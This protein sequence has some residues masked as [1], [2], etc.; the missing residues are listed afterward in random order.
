MARLLSSSFIKNVLL[1]LLQKFKTVQKDPKNAGCNGDSGN[2]YI[3]SGI[4]EVDYDVEVPFRNKKTNTT[5]NYTYTKKDVKFGY[6][7]AIG[8]DALYPDTDKNLFIEFPEEEVTLPD[9]KTAMV[10]P[11]KEYSPMLTVTDEAGEPTAEMLV[12]CV[13]NGQQMDWLQALSLAGGSYSAIFSA[14]ATVV[15]MIGSRGYKTAEE[16][17]KEAVKEA[18]VTN[19][20]R[21]PLPTTI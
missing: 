9:G 10:T 18:E 2:W 21:E 13:I 5:F 12:I 11:G 1:L 8:I 20:A 15:L 19:M 17:K 14:F 4:P 7:E 6:I 3:V 16:K